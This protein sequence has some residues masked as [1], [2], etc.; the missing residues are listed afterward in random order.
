M[1]GGASPKEREFRPRGDG[2]PQPW[3]LRGSVSQQLTAD[4]RC[5]VLAEVVRAARANDVAA[6]AWGLSS[7]AEQVGRSYGSRR[8]RCRAQLDPISRAAN[9]FVTSLF[10]AV[11]I[12]VLDEAIL[13]TRA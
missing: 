9:P 2:L 3:R 13:T 4:A 8:G 12:G 5:P 11:V 6:R 7:G 10:T 1:L